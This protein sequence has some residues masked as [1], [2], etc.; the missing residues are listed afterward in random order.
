[1]DNDA[2]AADDDDDAG[3]GGGGRTGSRKGCWSDGIDSCKGEFAV[4]DDE[5]AVDDE[6]G[7]WDR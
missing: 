6:D 5:D 2:A 4:D 1:M 3:G 7:V